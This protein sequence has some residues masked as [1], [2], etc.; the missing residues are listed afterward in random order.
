MN[1][2]A[3]HRHK[4]VEAIMADVPF[5]DYSQMMKDYV[6]AEAVKLL[7]PEVRAVYDNE[8]LRPYLA[9][10]SLS[11]SG[12]VPNPGSIFWRRPY[13]TD[14]SADA[15][16][17]HFTLYLDRAHWNGEFE[18]LTKELM[19]KVKEQCREWHRLAVKQGEERDAMRQKLQTIL[20]GIRSLKQAKTMLEP[21][22]H[23]YLPPEP[24]KDNAQKAAQAST[25]LVP[26]V[27]ANLR[28]MGWPKD[29]EAV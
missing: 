7:P 17:S 2:N 5:I 4:I 11:V 8:A 12:T 15:Y 14:K 10:Q 28:E 18:P 22:L 1:L 27:V 20:R 19:A 23:K 3:E 25:A 6:Q 24:P 21:E 29:K 26:Y 16:S 9:C 13:D